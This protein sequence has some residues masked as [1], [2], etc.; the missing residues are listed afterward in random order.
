MAAY[1]SDSD[2]EDYRDGRDEEKDENEKSQHSNVKSQESF[3]VR[4]ALGMSSKYNKLIDTEGDH[5]DEKPSKNKE[6]EET[7]SKKYNKLVDQESTNAKDSKVKNKPIKRNESNKKSGVDSKQEMKRISKGSDDIGNNR[8]LPKNTHITPSGAI[9][10][11]RRR[12]ESSSSHADEDSLSEQKGTEF[13]YRELDDE[14]GSRPSAHVTKKD[15]DVISMISTSS[16]EYDPTPKHL[17]VP[18]PRYSLSEPEQ[19]STPP[20]KPDPIIG[21]EHGVRPLLDDDELELAYDNGNP[22][23]KVSQS[24]SEAETIYTS[25]QSSEPTSPVPKPEFTDIFG[26]APFKKRASR[27]KRPSSGM[28]L[29]V[30]SKSDI[31]NKSSQVKPTVP[32]KPVKPMH[33]R[34]DTNKSN[35]PKTRSRRHA[36]G[37][38]MGMGLLGQSDDSDTEQAVVNDIFGNAPFMKR[39]SSSTDAVLRSSPIADHLKKF[40]VT[41]EQSYSTKPFDSRNGIANS[42][43]VDSLNLR[44]ETLPDS[45]GAIPFSSMQGKPSNSMKSH[46]RAMSEQ[47]TT[48]SYSSKIISQQTVSSPDSSRTTIPTNPTVTSP[49]SK[50]IIEPKPVGVQE[51]SK[52]VIRREREPVKSRELREPSPN[53]HKFKDEYDSDNDFGLTEKPKHMKN[54]QARSP[55]PPDRDMESSAF[56]NMSFNDDFEDEE[57]EMTHTG[58]SAS[59]FEGTFQSMKSSHSQN[60]TVGQGQQTRFVKDPSP[61]NQ[62]SV[63]PNDGG[64]D[65]FTW[66][67]KRHKVP[68]KPQATAE[69][70]TVKKRVDSIFK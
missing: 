27:K 38:E 13:Y 6:K 34:E 20:E 14:Y 24:N 8:V 23:N 47:R 19:S 61:V 28:N 56:S 45:F 57:N 25:P 17:P 10:K 48:A 41:D 22:Q 1:G 11:P 35:H 33:N 37:G 43:S 9:I 54:K 36:S 39:S 30:M 66:P 12:R 18:A 59:M 3:S 49:V 60:L 51:A 5:S 31:Y 67:R 53:Y 63:K 52:P 40:Y 29:G 4:A 46:A 2:N 26:A 65:T 55:R 64:Y 42:F 16:Q 68:T 50:P 44:S 58:M 32:P 15:H 21:H 62:D 70:F 69:P 7:S